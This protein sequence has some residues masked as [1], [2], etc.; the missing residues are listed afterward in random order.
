MSCSKFSLSLFTHLHTRTHTRSLTHPYI[1][2]CMHALTNTYIHSQINT[3]AHTHTHSPR[4]CCPSTAPQPPPPQPSA[5]I[6][7]ADQPSAFRGSVVVRGGPMVE[8]SEIKI[9]VRKINFFARGS[10]K[11]RIKFMAGTRCIR[12]SE[13]F[14]R[15]RTSIH[16][17]GAL[18]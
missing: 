17:M 3:H 1:H 5:V 4:L 6:A 2:D 18:H 16:S 12:G 7:A 13:I 11:G 14:V 10:E 9:V 15:C 8:K